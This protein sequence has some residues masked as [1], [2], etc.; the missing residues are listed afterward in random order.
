MISSLNLATISPVS[1]N[2]IN[3]N[4]MVSFSSRPSIK[5]FAPDLKQY[6]IPGLEEY[7]CGPV[8]AANGIIMQA[9]RGFSRLYQSQESK[10]LIYELGGYFNADKNGTTTANMITGLQSFVNAKGYNCNLKYQGF[11]PIDSK[12]KTSTLPNLDWIKGEINKNNTVLLNIGVYKKSVKDGKTIYTR[13]YG[14]FVTATGQGSN[15]ISM[16]PNCLT[17]HDPYNRVSGNHYIKTQEITQGK[18]IHNPDDNESTLTDNAVGFYEI[19]P[20]FNYFAN[21]EVG[22]LNGVISLEMLK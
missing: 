6:E 11:R 2:S 4:N 21:D 17:I 8:S 3:M 16:D 10:A 9:Q 20:K 14:H 5:T 12:Y 22:I 15:G 1:I 19:S 7:Y 13:Q 18:F